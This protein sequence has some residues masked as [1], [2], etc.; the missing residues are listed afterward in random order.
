MSQIGRIIS[1]VS[2]INVVLRTVPPISKYKIVWYV[3]DVVRNMKTKIHEHE[4]W[5]KVNVLAAVQN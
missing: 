4:A 5:L 3:F 2:R 1:L